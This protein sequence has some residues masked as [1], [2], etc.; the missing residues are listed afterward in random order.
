MRKSEAIEHLR[1]S[2]LKIES[3]N[4]VGSGFF[5]DQGLV[6]TCYHVVEGCSASELQLI[7]QGKTYKATSIESNP[8]DDLALISLK[9]D[10]KHPCVQV[11]KMVEV[12]DE[13]YSFGYST[14]HGDVISFVYEGEDGERL[15]KF[16]DGLF[17][18][19]LSGSPILNL[20][21]LKVCGV[22]KRTRDSEFPTGGRGISISKLFGFKSLDMDDNGSIFSKE[23]FKN[24]VWISS[25]ESADK[26]YPS[27]LA[28]L[29]TLIAVSF[30]F[31]LW[32]NGTYWHI[33]TGLIV[34]PLFFL[35]TQKGEKTSIVF[36]NKYIQLISKF[37]LII[38]T[39]LILILFIKM[40]LNEKCIGCFLFLPIVFLFIWGIFSP[41][42]ILFLSL[43]IKAFFTLINL[44]YQTIFLIP[45]NW[46]KII[47]STD[48]FHPLE[49]MPGIEKSNSIFNAENI[50]YKSF[51]PFTNS[52]FFKMISYEFR[53]LPTEFVT[54][55]PKNDGSDATSMLNLYIF[56]LVTIPTLFYRYSLKST[57]WIYLPLIWLI[58]PQD[59]S[60]LTTRMKIE[61]ENFIAYLMFFYSLIVVFIFTLLPL[62]FPHTQLGV[63]LQTFAIPPTLKTIFFAY[64]FNLWHLTRLVSALIT[65][66]FMFSF[67]KILIR[68]ETQPSYGD[69]WGAKLLSLRTLR[70][71]LTLITLGFTAYHILGL[72]PDNF[73]SD[74]WG[75][76]R[77]M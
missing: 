33:I 26:L 61:S 54:A 29:E 73:W 57:A 2:T 56:I 7:W 31:Y 72:L 60:D 24:W 63:Y 47:L 52:T 45:K 49:I 27:R 70:G 76:M 62:I 9:I 51:Y 43:F 71:V 44:S 30:S 13:C 32:I 3:Y 77:F 50:S 74:L 66:V 35:R 8:N 21:T 14:K 37:F 68:R 15:L 58:Q 18:S 40:F 20:K 64:E 69:F 19:G 10:K 38:I 55:P 17:Q 4:S 11:D 34:A 12:G 75:N 28:V 42:L 67:T 41:L 39:T 6:A 25:V 53:L 22:V 36:F 5:I 65:I 48:I 59:K 46:F 23:M 1:N 16:K